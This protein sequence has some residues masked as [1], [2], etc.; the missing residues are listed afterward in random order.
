[1][2]SYI[3]RVVLCNV[4][5][6]FFSLFDENEQKWHLATCLTSGSS[7]LVTHI[8]SPCIAI[9]FWLLRKCICLLALKMTDDA[10]WRKSRKKKKPHTL[11]HTGKMNVRRERESHLDMDVQSLCYNL[12]SNVD[13]AT[14][15]LTLISQ[16]WNFNDIF[17]ACKWEYIC[18]TW[19]FSLLL[20]RPF[21]MCDCITNYFCPYYLV[22]FNMKISQWK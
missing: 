2:V 21:G 16:K 19:F 22:L 7:H 3:C 14:T 18:D 13:T 4:L 1:M 12:Q 9:T 6:C 10:N 20:Q 8:E 5:V 15:V 11:I 17:C